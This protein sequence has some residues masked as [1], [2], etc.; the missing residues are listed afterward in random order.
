MHIRRTAAALLLLA[1]AA[2]TARE[3][4]TKEELAVQEAKLKTL[5]ATLSKRLGMPAAPAAPAAPGS[6]AAPKK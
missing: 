3:P 6:G 4:F 5:E 2:A 1:A